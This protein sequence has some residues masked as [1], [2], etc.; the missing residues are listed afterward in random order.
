MIKPFDSTVEYIWKKILS[1]HQQDYAVYENDRFYTYKELDD[2]S[3]A[4]ADEILRSTDSLRIGVMLDS[5]YDYV[6]AVLGILKAGKSFVPMDREWPGDRLDNIIK[7]AEIE[8]IISSDFYDDT[9]TIIN[10]DKI[11]H[12]GFASDQKHEWKDGNEAYV[13][14]SSGTTGEPKAIIIG[15]NSLVNLSLWFENTFLTEDINNVLQLAKTTFDVSVEEI[16]GTILNGRTLFIPPHIVRKHKFKLRQF[17]EEKD[18]N[19]IEVVPA[20]LTEFFDREEK[21]PCLKTIICGADVLREELKNS[22]IKL[23]YDLYN[24]YG[25]TETTVDAMYYKCCLTEPVQLG[26]CVDGCE[27]AILAEDGELVTDNSEGELLIAGVNLTTGYLKNDELNEQ[28]FLY[29]P[30]GKRYYR[31]GDFVKTDDKGRVFYKGRTDHQVKIRGQRIEIEEIEKAFADGMKISLC[32][33]VCIKD[34]GEKIVLFY[35]SDEAIDYKH[36]I[37]GMREKLPEYMLPSEYQWLERLPKTENGKVDRSALLDYLKEIP[38]EIPDTDFQE[39][40]EDTVKLLNM[41][42]EATGENSVDISETVER[43]GFDSLSYV[44][45]LVEVECIWDVELGDDL[46]VPDEN[47]TVETLIKKIKVII[48]GV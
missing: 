20:T 28:R 10:M 15:R 29:S 44:R 38:K 32:A 7:R 37:N 12:N 40:D 25:P 2:R 18:I 1:D 21:I 9:L 47:E 30:S 23:G 24:N 41:I 33:A 42:K 4:V 16:F 5:S 31:T 45:F 36:I 11:A 14:H 26:E 46:L 13:M 34:K 6:C 27:I 39:F 22:I 8:I 3:W 43:A 19:L 17:V 48:T 35:E